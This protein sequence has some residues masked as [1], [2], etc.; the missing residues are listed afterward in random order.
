MLSIDTKHHIHQCKVKQNHKQG[1]EIG[2]IL[3]RIW[4][5]VFTFLNPYEDQQWIS[6]KPGHVPYYNKV[7]WF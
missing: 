1:Q 2:Q 3:L 5:T 7:L 4:A 6:D